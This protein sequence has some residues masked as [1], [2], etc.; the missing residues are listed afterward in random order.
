MTWEQFLKLQDYLR[1]RTFKD[2]LNVFCKTADVNQDGLLSYQEILE[3]CQI[4]L[5]KNFNSNN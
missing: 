2:K 3:L 4:S 1:A 5:S